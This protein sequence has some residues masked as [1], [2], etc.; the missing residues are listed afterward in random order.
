MGGCIESVSEKLKKRIT[1][2]GVWEL[3]MHLVCFRRV[4]VSFSVELDLAS[5]HDIIGSVVRP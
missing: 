2:I 1:R 4:F 5:D 3:V